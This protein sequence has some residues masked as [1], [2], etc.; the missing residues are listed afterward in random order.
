MADAG[1]VGAE[2]GRSAL[3]RWASLPASMQVIVAE[4]PDG[5]TETDLV[6]LSPDGEEVY[7]ETI[8][9]PEF[10]TGGRIYVVR[11]LP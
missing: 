2:G 11:R 7:A 3:R 10:W 4:I 8:L 6:Y 1:S 5:V 9:W